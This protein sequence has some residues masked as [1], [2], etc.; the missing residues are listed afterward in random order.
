MG[1]LILL[2]KTQNSCS[3]RQ[4]PLKARRIYLKF[5]FFTTVWHWWPPMNH[6]FQ[7]SCLSCH[8]SQWIC[9]GIA[10]GKW[11]HQ[12]NAGIPIKP[13]NDGAKTC[14]T[15]ILISLFKGFVLFLSLCS[16]ID[17]HL[18]HLA[19][20][21]MKGCVGSYNSRFKWQVSHHILK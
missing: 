21:F 13:M 19:L 1:S 17:A 14:S 16:G 12:K 15:V 9:F 5:S 11:R 2:G 20:H 7:Y 10:D 8:L 18:L 4:S 3:D 6:R